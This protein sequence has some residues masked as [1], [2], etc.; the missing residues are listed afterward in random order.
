MQ[1]K[2]GGAFPQ[3]KPSPKRLAFE[4][5]ERDRASLNSNQLPSSGEISS[6]VGPPLSSFCG[7]KFSQVNHPGRK[8]P[9]RPGAILPCQPGGILPPKIV[10]IKRVKVKRVSFRHK[11]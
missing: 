4:N 3:L 1:V 2:M 5:G 9:P 7:T 10:N 8:M 6:P 11:P